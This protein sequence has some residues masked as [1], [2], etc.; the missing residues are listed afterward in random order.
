MAIGVLKRLSTA[1]RVKAQA[2]YRK[3]F[4]VTKEEF[5]KGFN[6]Q[7]ARGT[8]SNN[9]TAKNPGNP[10]RK[11]AEFG[12]QT[13]AKVRTHD[14]TQKVGAGLTT[15]KEHKVKTGMVVGAGMGVAAAVRS[16][17]SGS[18]SSSQSL[19]RN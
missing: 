11:A 13:A 5:E 19:Y 12:R 10:K 4:T 9:G 2:R 6:K 16:I 14:V 8:F 17:G 3:N 1:R 18:A 7:T 15:M